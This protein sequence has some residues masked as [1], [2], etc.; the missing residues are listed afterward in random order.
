MAGWYNH[1]SDNDIDWGNSP[2]IEALDDNV[3]I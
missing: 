3:L 2:D 1:N